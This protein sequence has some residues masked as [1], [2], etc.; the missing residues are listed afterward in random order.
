MFIEKLLFKSKDGEQ[1][2][3]IKLR[4]YL[5]VI[6]GKN[7]AGKTRT[8]NVL[9]NLSNIHKAPK[10]THTG[11]WNMVIKGE[12]ETYSYELDVGIRDRKKVVIQDSLYAGEI[13]RKLIFDRA[14]G[15]LFNEVT[16]S[17]EAY[18]PIDDELSLNYV[19]DV[20]KYKTALEVKDYLS[21]FKR[22]DYS[23]SKVVGMRFVDNALMVEPDG[24]G[25]DMAIINIMTQYPSHFEK[26]K[27]YFVEIFPQVQDL[28]ILNIQVGNA[29]MKTIFI[30]EN[31]LDKPYAYFEAASGMI[32]ILALLSILFSPAEKS[33]ILIDELENSLD[34]ISLVKIGDII[35]EV[36]LDKQIV[37]VTHSP[38]LAN[39]FDLKDWIVS[40][41]ERRHTKFFN[42][43]EDENLKILLSK[44]LENY[45]LYT[46]NLLPLDEQE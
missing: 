11:T 6:F 5:N 38:V 21:Q 36:C 42:V 10:P 45:S 34:Y 4:E 23:M 43:I 17:E 16:E 28:L 32:K 41:R 46:Q 29:I 14:K 20:K 22:L 15:S 30:K 24:T 3:P 40:E 31:I 25:L 37:I 8:L 18:T 26:I 39:I 33:L 35:K 13:G 27:S 12:K 19:K 44:N 1:I 9:F 7:A 2:G